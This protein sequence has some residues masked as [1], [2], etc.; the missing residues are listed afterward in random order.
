MTSAMDP[1]TLN[2]YAH[3]LALLALA[4]HEHEEDP[5]TFL[6]VSIMSFA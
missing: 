4:I 3:M 1:K 6:A 2:C 5:A